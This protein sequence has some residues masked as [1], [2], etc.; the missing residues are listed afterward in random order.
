[1][2]EREE[3]E[4]TYYPTARVRLIVRLEDYGDA[5]T[6][7]PP[8]TIATVRRGEK[9]ATQL[10]VVTM[11]N[12]ALLLEGTGGQQGSPQQQTQSA[13]EYTHVID[14]I[15]PR[16]A[17]L[18]RNGLRDADTLS[19]EIKYRD[20]PIDP[21]V[22][23]SCAVQF[24]LGTVTPED[25]QRGMEGESRSSAGDSPVGLPYHVVPD[26]YTDPN[27]QQ[28]TNLRFE[29]WVDEWEDEWP[30]GEG[31]V[32]RLECTDN[33]RLLIEQDAPPKLTIGS[34]VPVHQ[35]IANYLA[36]FPQFR[37]LSVEYR[38]RV[39]DSQIPTLVDVLQ[40]TAMRPELGPS[41]AKGGTSKLKVWDYITD[42]VGSVGHVVRVEGTTIVIQKARTL[43][44]TRFAGRPDDPFFAAPRTLAGGRLPRRLLVYGRNISEMSFARKF[45]T[46]APQNIEVRCYDTERKKT[47]TARF[48]L[49]GDEQKRINPGEASDQKWFVVR[50]EGI[51]DEKTLRLVAQNVYEQI[52]RNE[53]VGRILTKNLG[54]FGGGNLDPDALDMLPGDAVDVVIQRS[55]AGQ[56]DNTVNGVEAQIAA[57]PAE[58]LQELGFDAR[59]AAAYAKAVTSIGL[60]S[61]FRVRTVSIDWDAESD[62][63]SLDL[64]VM[65]YVEVRADK[66][67]EAS[68]Q[69]AP[70]ATSGGAAPAV[71][72]DGS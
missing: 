16:A 57:R 9:A 12:G 28:R 44:D 6:P 8:E 30:Q 17:T 53:L 68:E 46:Y 23:R 63:V 26:E 60:Q 27:G 5:N 38:P 61:T 62:G 50:V 72:E 37:G 71:Q 67:L 4:Q 35:A 13:D 39:P 54:T 32:V 59:F 70:E 18:N 47:L 55:E 49:K 10:Q 29:G 36:N 14:G 58:Y 20:M 19:I 2:T 3:P 69:T 1:M 11:E 24:F 41:V 21:R 40:K 25:Y 34:K 66:D 52:G 43:Y 15:I 64:E 33:T 65:N 31:P 22:I 56:D 51:R 48:P 45:S 7:A 42:V